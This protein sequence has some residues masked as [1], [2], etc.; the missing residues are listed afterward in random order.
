MLFARLQS[1]LTAPFIVAP[2]LVYLKINLHKQL[3]FNNSIIS[4]QRFP[5]I[6][7]AVAR[8]HSF[9]TSSKESRVTQIYSK[10]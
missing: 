3:R 4:L 7:P 1:P 6:D 2:S 10:S 5:D 9:T 8:R